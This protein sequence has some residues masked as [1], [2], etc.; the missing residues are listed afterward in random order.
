MTRTHQQLIDLAMDSLQED[1]NSGPPDLET[2]DDDEES[3]NVIPKFE[4]QDDGI[5]VFMHNINIMIFP[6]EIIRNNKQTGQIV[7]L[8]NI[9]RGPII[10][11]TVPQLESLAVSDNGA[12]E[13]FKIYEANDIWI[14]HGIDPQVNST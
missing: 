4:V 9:M 10:E 1:E 6:D 12:S 13:A 7:P 3:V 8:R 14:Q 2:E 11:P 5:I